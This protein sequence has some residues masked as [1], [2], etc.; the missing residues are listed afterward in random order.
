MQ[1]V[2][3]MDPANELEYLRVA[4]KHNE[5]LIAPDDNFTL[6]VMQ[7]HTLLNAPEKEKADSEINFRG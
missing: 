1:V 5:I 2:R 3:A 6:V 4:S 7:N